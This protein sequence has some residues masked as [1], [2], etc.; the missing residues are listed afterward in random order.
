MASIVRMPEVLAN[1]T[2]A[3]IQAWLV[4]KGQIVAVGAPLA[5]V[6]TDKAVVEFE[7]EV[8][9][10]ILDLLVDAG[11]QVSVGEPIAV[12]GAAGDSGPGPVDPLPAFVTEPVQ[13]E[14]AATGS[15]GDRVPGDREL[16]ANGTTRLFASPLVRRL[17]RE[18]GLDLTTIAGTGPGGRIVRRDVEARPRPVPA[19]AAPEPAAAAEPT[20]ALSPASAP[21]PATT[22]PARSEQPFEDVPLTGMRQAIARRLTQSKST[23][24]HFYLTADIVLDSLLE[25]RKRVNDGNENRISVT[26]LLVKAAA[27][28]FVRVPETNA[29]WA[30]TAIRRYASVDL[31][32]AVAIEGGLV[33]PVLRGVQHLSVGAVSAAV[34]DLA[35]RARAGRL[36]QQELEGGCFTLSNLGM[37]GVKEFAAIINPPQAS[38]LA[39]GAART[40][41]VVEGGEIVVRSVMSVTL[42]ADHRVIDGAL[43]ARWMAAFVE[44][45]E[46][47]MR[48]LV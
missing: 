40:V 34:A 42:S 6:E 28:A 39:V 26:D 41:P 18:L 22:S 33:T 44:L 4:E 17:A 14:P 8:A 16:G 48:I 10:T 32:V 13:G 7:S 5:E 9:G 12:I 38:I 35:G 25:L 30:E 11:T 23:V 20:P 21:A 43:A 24:P 3:T 47:P 1:A 46:N 31:A 29:S 45:C 37:Y 15:P 19:P 2:E 27:G 36:R